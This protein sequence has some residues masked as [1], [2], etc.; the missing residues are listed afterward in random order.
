VPTFWK[1]YHQVALTDGTIQA[2]A[3][4]ADRPFKL[5]AGQGIF[6]LV[7]PS[8][9]R[10]WRLQHRMAGKQ[11]LVALGVYPQVSL[12]EAREKRADVGKLI[13]NGID[14]VEAIREQ[15]GQ[16]KGEG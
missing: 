14:P 12:R 11:K 16:R 4:S 6:L 2:K 8:D 7:K 15:Q 13:R 5:F 1:E 3:R 9:A 10:Y